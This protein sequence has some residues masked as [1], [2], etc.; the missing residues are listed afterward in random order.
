MAPSQQKETEDFGD[1]FEAPAKPAQ[2]KEAKA[3]AMPVA[4]PIP[5]PKKE[6]NIL[7][8]AKDML[9]MDDLMKVDN[10]PKQNKNNNT[11]LYDALYGKPAYGGNKG[12]Y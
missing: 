10:G 3:F 1:F 6:S 11:N 12:F 8:D 7:N 5:A 2:K 4:A 9:D